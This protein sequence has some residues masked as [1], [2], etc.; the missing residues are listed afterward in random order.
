ME[1]LINGYSGTY[2]LDIVKHTRMVQLTKLFANIIELD[3]SIYIY[4]Y[5]YIYRF[6][7]VYYWIRENEFA[8]KYYEILS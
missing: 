6:S 1:T 5:I 4:I 2:D 3:L 7:T 8:W